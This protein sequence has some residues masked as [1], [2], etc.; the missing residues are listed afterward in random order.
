MVRDY[1]KSKKKL[2][3][4]ALLGVNMA[5]EVT[6]SEQP[7]QIRS[8]F[9]ITSAFCAIRTNGVL[10]MDN[11]N[12]ALAGRGYG[13]SSTNAM[14][15]LENGRNDISID[16]GAID[17]FE[18]NN[19]DKKGVFS[20]N[21]SCHLALTAFNNGKTVILQTIDVAVD[22]K[23]NPY[24][25]NITKSEIDKSDVRVEKI[26]TVQV[27]EGHFP[28]EYYNNLDF[29]K[30]MYVYNFTKSVKITGIPEWKWIKATS[31]TGS[32]EQIIA[33]QQAY[34]KL[35]K[36]FSTKKDSLI[37]AEVQESLKAWG[38]STNSD[39]NSIY[40]DLEFVADLKN[41]SFRMIP[42]KWEDYRVDVMNKG[43]MVRF[44]NKSTPTYSPI[45]YVVKDKENEE[46]IGT[47]S[48]IFSLVNGVFIPVI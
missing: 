28:E 13:T 27:E 34:E 21:A 4:I 40:E 15:F 41:T 19:I 3:L 17:W 36:A 43:R 16:F 26:K 46:L 6:A 48:P 11:R 5:F 37:K 32:Q 44:V 35:W 29:P 39:P 23:N 24:E 20:P 1:M 10:G 30:N 42:I 18:D 9:N 25:K 12:S 7:L 47:Y 45:T 38:V 8:V 2:F 22:E 14:L 33:L 31:F